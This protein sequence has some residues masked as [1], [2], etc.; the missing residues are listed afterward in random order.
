[1][2]WLPAAPAFLGFRPP[3]INWQME[4]LSELVENYQAWYFLRQKYPEI[5]TVQSMETHHKKPFGFYRMQGFIEGEEVDWFMKLVPPLQAER[6]CQAL[7]VAHHLNQNGVACAVSL[8][9][10]PIEVD[11]GVCALTYDYIEGRF[12]D[13]SPEDLATLGD[14]IGH[15]HKALKTYPDRK[16]IEQAG[17]KRHQML[18]SRWEFL[19]DTPEEMAKLPKR[20]QSMLKS[21]SPYWLAHIRE[22]AQMV[23]GDLNVGNI[24]FVPDGSVVILDLE[25]SLTAWFDPLKDLAFVIERFVLTVHEDHQVEEMSHIFLDAYF[26]QHPT[27]VQTPDRFVDLLQGLAIRACLLLAEMQCQNTEIDCETEWHKFHFLYK[28]THQYHKQLE[29]IAR[30]YLKD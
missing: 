8:E 3:E 25:D 1:M 10:I 19:L 27:E 6:H 29:Q 5:K 23:H 13:Y 4:S 11:E 2:N 12:C 24:L 9:E 30:P 7:K 28:L 14:T 26:A 17:I 22:D 20:V 21:H 16:A 18:V 15:L